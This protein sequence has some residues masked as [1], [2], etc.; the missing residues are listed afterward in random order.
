MNTV[1]SKWLPLYVIAGV[2]AATGLFMLFGV[3]WP[4]AL[5]AALA[6]VCPLLLIWIYFQSSERRSKEK[7]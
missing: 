3:S 6:A 5:L 7:S 2:G 1:A 4:A